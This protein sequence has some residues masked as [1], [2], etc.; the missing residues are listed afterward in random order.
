[1]FSAYFVFVLPSMQHALG[2]SPESKSAEIFSCM[3]SAQGEHGWSKHFQLVPFIA[4]ETYQELC[5]S[6]ISSVPNSAL[7]VSMV[8]TCEHSQSRPVGEICVL[9]LLFPPSHPYFLLPSA[10]WTFHT[11][12]PQAARGAACVQLEASYLICLPVCPSRGSAQGRGKHTR[13]S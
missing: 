6:G 10:A 3:Q 8:A 7:N 2:S 1:M 11:K 4:L 13:L 12:V 5:N 9:P